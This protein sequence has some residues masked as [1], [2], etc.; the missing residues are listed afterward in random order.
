MPPDQTDHAR[1][2]SE[3]VH[4][5]GDALKRYLQRSFPAVRDVDDVVQESYLRVWRRQLAR[6]ISQV[7]GPVTASVKSFLFQVARRL[8]IDALRRR[9]ASPID[10]DAV[11]DF[12]APSVLENG[13]NSRD[14]ACNQQEFEL[15]LD[16]IDALPPRCREV[17]V[18]RKLQGKSV[19]ETALHLGISQETVQVHTRRGLQRM[20]EVL[21]RAGV[22]RECAS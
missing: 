17:I 4:P 2:F 13:P 15:L 7:T 12:S 22:I 14:A 1:W 5:H 21:Q 3:E 10:P 20:Q 19:A 8:A 6:P 18:L 11:T 16:A 9:R